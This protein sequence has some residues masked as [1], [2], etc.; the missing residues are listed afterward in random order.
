[1]V[2]LS[3]ISSKID[4]EINRY[5]QKYEWYQKYYHIFQL[6]NFLRIL[7]YAKEDSVIKFLKNVLK[8]LL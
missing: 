1:M 6:M 4:N 3:I 2:R 5:Y 8:S 7:Q